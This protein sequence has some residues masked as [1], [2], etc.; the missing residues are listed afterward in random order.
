MANAN[1]VEVDSKHFQ[2]GYSNIEILMM[3]LLLL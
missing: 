3:L 2:N 1:N